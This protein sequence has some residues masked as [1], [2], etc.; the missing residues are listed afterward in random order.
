MSDYI[1]GKI[2]ALLD[3][4]TVV[5]NRG[6]YHNVGIGDTFYIYSQI[7]PFTDPETGD[8]LG[9]TTKVW[10]KVE[11]TIVEDGFCVARTQYRGD[12]ML[13]RFNGYSADVL[14]CP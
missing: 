1:E 10:G 2:A 6:A 4:T 3:K 13:R 14:S 5:I 7:G 12:S 11:V 9:T 8:D